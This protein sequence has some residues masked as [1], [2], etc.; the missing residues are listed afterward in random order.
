MCLAWLN[1]SQGV[2]VEKIMEELLGKKQ[3]RNEET[4]R[5]AAK[6]MAKNQEDNEKRWRNRHK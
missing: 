6:M 1:C 4:V 3:E 2:G 5:E